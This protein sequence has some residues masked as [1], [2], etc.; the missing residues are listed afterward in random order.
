MLKRVPVI[1]VPG[2]VFINCSFISDLTYIMVPWCQIYRNGRID[3]RCYAIE[4]IPL[5]LIGIIIYKVARNYNKIRIDPVDRLTA[6]S[7]KAVSLSNPRLFSRKPICG[8]VI[9][10]NK[11]GK[12]RFLP[13]A[14]TILT[15]VHVRNSIKRSLSFF[16]Y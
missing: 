8:S 15:M 5:T 2:N 6:F 4:F 12:V 13:W 3:L 11:K 7:Y 14:P 10:T 9:C 1:L 16:K